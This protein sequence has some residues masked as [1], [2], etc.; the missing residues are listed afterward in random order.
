MNTKGVIRLQ[1]M[2]EVSGNDLIPKITP[3]LLEQNHITM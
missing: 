1:N 2:E 3:S